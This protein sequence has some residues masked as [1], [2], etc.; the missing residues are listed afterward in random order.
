M[1]TLAA[2]V[3]GVTLAGTVTYSFMSEEPKVEP[4]PIKQEVVQPTTIKKYEK[5]K[6]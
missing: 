5:T 6:E 3:L 4:E 2:F 1:E